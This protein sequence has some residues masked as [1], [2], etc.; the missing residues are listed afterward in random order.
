MV[1]K[2]WHGSRLS[3]WHYTS[4]LKKRQLLRL[5]HDSQFLAFLSMDRYSNNHSFK[6]PF[7]SLSWHS[8]SL[9]HSSSNQSA[10]GS[11]E[12]GFPQLPPEALILS[13]VAPSL[14]HFSVSVCC[15]THFWAYITHLWSCF[16]RPLD[17]YNDKLT[18]FIVHLSKCDF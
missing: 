9:D 6:L 11:A 8:F 10:A 12:L 15:W 3:L 14:F 2:A 7:V 4:L 16:S 5:L 18:I 13:F 1:C 17:S